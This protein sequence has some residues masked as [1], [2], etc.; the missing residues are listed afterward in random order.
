MPRHLGNEGLEAGGGVGWGG[1]G[2]G[3]GVEWSAGKRQDSEPPPK[4]SGA[5]AK[6]RM[7][8]PKSG[9]VKIQTPK[10]WAQTEDLE[11]FSKLLGAA[12]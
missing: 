5:K 10:N 12:S 8:T 1:G 11:K 3:V 6:I 9:G 2:W 7:E 4:H